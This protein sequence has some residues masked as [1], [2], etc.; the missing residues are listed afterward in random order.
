MEKA[1]IV[2]IGSA[3]MDFTAKSAKLPLPGQTVLGN[4]F[5]MG[6]GGKGANQAVAVQRLG[7]N[8]CFITKLGKDIN[9]ELIEKKYKEEGMDTSH[10]L[11]SDTHSGVALILVDDKGE[12]CIIMTPGANNDITTSDIDSVAPIIKSARYLVVQ[13][14]IPLKAVIR[15]V[16]IADEAGVYVIFNPAPA[17]PL[18]D[19]IYPHVSLITPNETEV[20]AIT[21]CPITSDPK[22]LEK[23]V[24]ILRSKGVKNIIVTLGS[25]GSLVCEQGKEPV[26]VPIVKTNAMD[27]TG[28][29]DTFSGAVC[30]ALSEGKSLIEAAQFATRACSLAVQR[31]GA[32]AG[33]PL[34]KELED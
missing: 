9:G 11:Y 32:M 10:I 25:H 12:N 4:S 13:L 18:P 28:A 23:P 31:M 22:E 15:A 30:V 5:V 34:R 2:V 19:E 33:I 27:T 14:E 8:V 16:E 7:A 24:S 26:L 29:G 6:P 1:D 17:C 3:T 21:G 20:A